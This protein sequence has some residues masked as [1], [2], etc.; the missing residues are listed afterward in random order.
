MF[1]LRDYCYYSW[2]ERSEKTGSVS[3]IPENSVSQVKW[4]RKRVMSLILEY[5]IESESGTFYIS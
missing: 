4:E 3:Q 5:W 1:G 2:E